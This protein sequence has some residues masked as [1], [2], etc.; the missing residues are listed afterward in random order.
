M[1]PAGALRSGTLVNALLHHTGCGAIQ[2]GVLEPEHEADDEEVRRPVGGGLFVGDRIDVQTAD[3]WECDARVLG[4]SES[5]DAGQIRVEFAMASW[6][7]GICLIA[8]RPT[9]PA[10]H[11]SLSR[12][13]SL[14]LSHSWSWRCAPTH[15]P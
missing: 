6:T 15:H 12:N 5:G 1:H 14:S 4:P 10:L 7:T 2:Q 3:G 9:T 13:L 11:L 8:V